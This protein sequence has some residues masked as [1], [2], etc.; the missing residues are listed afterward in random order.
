MTSTSLILASGSPRRR[1]LLEA[2]G[3]EFEVIQ[4]DADEMAGS[5]LTPRDL[6]CRNAEIKAG[7]VAARYPN[8]WVLGADTAVAL[9]DRIF[10]KPRSMK[11]AET[12]LTTLQGQRHQVYTGV[13]LIHRS[14]NSQETWCDF[15]QVGFR[16]L[17]P[18]QIQDYLARIEPL[19]KAGAYAIQDDGERIVGRIEGSLSNVVGLPL[20]SLEDALDRLNIR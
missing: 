2:L 4:S 15:T 12:M 18:R 5:Q 17:S 10:G 1:E 20:E 6:V 8:R 16:R 11:E 3:V 13:C 9:D 14:S 19:D 7:D